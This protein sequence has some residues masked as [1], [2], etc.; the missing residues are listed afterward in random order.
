MPG[1]LKIIAIGDLHFGHPRLSAEATYKK[2]RACLYP[3]LETAHAIFIT[4]DIYDQLLTVNSKAHRFATMFI[5]DLLQVSAKTG[6]QVRL[7][8]GTFTHDRD[9]LGIFNT[10]N[11]PNSRFKVINSIYVEELNHFQCND[12]IIEET[13]RVGYLPDNLSYKYSSD[14]VEQLKTTMSVAG[15]SLLDLLI[16]HG[17]F[18]HVIPEST[19]RPSCLYTIRQFDKI[20]CGPLIFGHIH[21]P[22]HLE[23]MYY[24]GSFE[25]MTHGEEEDK[26]FYVFTADINNKDLRDRWRARFVKNKFT[27]PFI[28]ITP[29]VTTDI[30][31]IAKD[32]LNKIDELFPNHKGFVRVLHPNPEVRTVLHRLCA[33]HYPDLVYSSK[34]VGD[35]ERTEM[36]IEDI[37][38]D[39]LDD[40]R[41]NINNLGDLVYQ[42]LD[43]HQLLG[44]F[45]KDQIVQ[46]TAKL[47]EEKT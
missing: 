22:G 35:V 15:Y 27:I 2:L 13:L 4:G 30:P 16:G 45:T 3:E 11:I 5:R 10:L 17:S 41:P 31:K 21:T 7:L 44:S 23:N 43:E 26:G 42:F 8:H 9:Q 24:C 38:L 36:H 28:S 20:V 37:Q 12:E 46:A 47:C 32:F 33:Q 19:R 25:R 6:M 34:S 18:E 14:A 29:E 39:V 1:I 40:I